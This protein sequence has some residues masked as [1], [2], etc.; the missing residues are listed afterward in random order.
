MWSAPIS[1]CRA[2]AAPSSRRW[3]SLSVA[4]I[5]NIAHDH[6]EHYATEMDHVDAYEACVRTGLAEKGMLVLN[7]DSEECREL[8]SRLAL[9]AGDGPRVVTFGISPSAGWQLTSASSAGGRSTATLTGP[10]GLEL[11]LVLRVPGVHQLMNAAATV[12]TLHALGQDHDQAV[13][14]L[15]YLDGALRRMTPAGQAAGVRLYDSFSHH[16]YDEVNADLAAAPS[17]VRGD[18]RVLVVFQPADEARLSAF[19][20][21]FGMAL[22]GCDEVVLTDSSRGAVTQHARGMAWFMAADQ[23]RCPAERESESDTPLDAAAWRC[24]STRLPTRSGR[25]A[26]SPSYVT[27]A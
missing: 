4:V 1:T 15:L 25:R 3:T 10:G 12:A 16:H 5:T 6:L 27:T 19:G 20:D 26:R 17:L 11:D 14:Q 9:A 22:A 18:G 24:A 13:E 21:E 23:V 7:A 2:A 8:A